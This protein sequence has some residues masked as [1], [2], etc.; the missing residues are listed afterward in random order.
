VTVPPLLDS[1]PPE[2][3]WIYA[4]TSVD[5]IVDGLNQYLA[6]DRYRLILARDQTEFLANLSRDRQKI[7]CLILDDDI[8][9][10]PIVDWLHRQAMLLPTV[11]VQTQVHRLRPLNL[12]TSERELTCHYH[13]AEVRLPMTELATLKQTIDSAIAAFLNLSPAK[14]RPHLAAVAADVAPDLTAQ[15]FVLLQQQRLAEKLN[16]RLGYLGVY[17]KRNPNNFLRALAPEEA[18]TFLNE[19]KESYQNIILGYFNGDNQ[20]NQKIDAFVDIAFFADLSVAEV[21]EIHMDLIGEFAKQLRLEGRSEEVLTDYRLT[22]IDT[23]A[24][25][26]EMYRRSIPRDISDS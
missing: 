2:Q 19:L 15:N 5:R 23:L 7:D 22:L 11:I 12:P 3:L 13:T 21:V 9:L 14:S 8:H 6:H 16:E 20:I 24:H 10:S 4:F 17:Y 25:L 18:T 1:P 26:C